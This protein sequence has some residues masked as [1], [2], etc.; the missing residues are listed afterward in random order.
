MER[1]EMVPYAGKVLVV[2]TVRGTAPNEKK[3]K[4]SLAFAGNGI[5][6]RT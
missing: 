3:R 5:A 6:E 2:E 1:R 4:N